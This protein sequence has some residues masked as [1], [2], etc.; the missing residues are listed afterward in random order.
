MTGFARQQGNSPKTYQLSPEQLKGKNKITVKFHAPPD[1][2]GGSVY[3]VR[4]LKVAAD[5]AAQQ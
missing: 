4:I 3:G 2:R 1:S 5:S